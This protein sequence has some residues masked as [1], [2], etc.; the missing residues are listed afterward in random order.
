MLN[1]GNISCWGSNFK[2]QLGYGTT[3]SYI[4]TT[5]PNVSD[6]I[7]MA[8]DFTAVLLNNGTLM[9]WG[10]VDVTTPGMGVITNLPWR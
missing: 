1:T 8:P 5:V 3:D 4:P 7:D 10:T 2:G 6:V 9:F